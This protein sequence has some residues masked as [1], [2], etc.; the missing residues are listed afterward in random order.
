MNNENLPQVYNDGIFGK[1]R[2]FFKNLFLKKKQI[3]NVSIVSSENNQIDI[4]E[5][6]DWFEQFYYANELQQMNK[7]KN[8][9]EIM[10]N[11][12]GNKPELL[13]TASIETLRKIEETYNNI[14]KENNEKIKLL[15][16]KIEQ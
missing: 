16:G 8:R 3:E 9:K 1:I 2:R 15:K 4:E 13:D 6:K 12:I 10:I 7:E 14:I 5:K 11:T